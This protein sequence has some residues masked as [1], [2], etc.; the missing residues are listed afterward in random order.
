MPGFRAAPFFVIFD[1]QSLNYT[2]V[3]NA[4]P[5][6]LMAGRRIPY[7]EQWVN[8]TAW[9]VL[10]DNLAVRIRPYAN[11]GITTIYNMIGGTGDVNNGDSGATMYATM[12]AIAVT[13]KSYGVDI[14]VATTIMPSIT[15]IGAEITARNDA[16]TLI[17]ADA[18]GSFNYKV[19]LAAVAGLDDATNATYYG[20]GTHWLAAGATLAKDTLAPTYNT[21]TGV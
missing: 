13:V 16:N 20:D 1:G 11:A 21:I 9:S 15:H 12:S 19:N 8:G 5:A 2:P 17:M 14:V 10:D 3:G 7:T 18:N 6:Q 4:L